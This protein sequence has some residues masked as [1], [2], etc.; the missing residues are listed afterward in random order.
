M[1][2]NWFNF[3]SNVDL[4]SLFFFALSGVILFIC[5]GLFRSSAPTPSKKKV[6]DQLKSLKTSV[7]QLQPN[8]TEHILSSVNMPASRGRTRKNYSNLVKE[9]IAAGEKG[10][11]VGMAS[12]PLTIQNQVGSS[13][14]GVDEVSFEGSQESLNS[15]DDGETCTVESVQS[16]SVAPPNPPNIDSQRYVRGV[17]QP[18][19]PNL[20]SIQ[21]IKISE[22]V[23]EQVNNEDY[24]GNDVVESNFV[25]VQED[26]SQKVIHI[27]NSERRSCY[28]ID[29]PM[30]IFYPS[31]RI[32]HTVFL[33]RKTSFNVLKDKVTSNSVVYVVGEKGLGKTTLV[34]H[35][36]QYA[37]LE[38]GFHVLSFSF[39][40]MICDVESACNII[41]Q[42]QLG[43]DYSEIDNSL[44]MLIEYLRNNKIL[45]VL[46]HCEYLSQQEVLTLG[47]FYD[48][49]SKVIMVFSGDSEEVP[50]GNSERVVQLSS[51]DQVFCQNL[52]MKYVPDV[53][54]FQSQSLK[55]IQ[56]LS[57]GNLLSLEL[58]GQYCM[59][60]SERNKGEYLKQSFFADR[61]REI[62]E[63]KVNNKSTL[64]KLFKQSF[65]TLNNLEKDVLTIIALLP[66]QHLSEYTL[67]FFIPS[68][69]SINLK[70]ILSDL[71]SKG[72][73][74]TLYI[75]QDKETL[76]SIHSAFK[77][78]LRK[79]AFIEPDLH[80][81]IINASLQYCLNICNTESLFEKE[82]LSNT[83]NLFL[84]VLE[85]CS[86]GDTFIN[87]YQ[88]LFDKVIRFAASCGFE[89]TIVNNIIPLI[90]DNLKEAVSN[91]EILL[92]KRYLGLSIILVADNVE[93]LDKGMNLVK[94][95]HQAYAYSPAHQQI[96]LTLLAKG[97]MKRNSL[98]KSDSHLDSAIEA[99]E[100]AHNLYPLEGLELVELKMD[101][102]SA[103]LMKH[104][105]SHSELN[106]YK[107]EYL[108]KALSLFN[109]INQTIKEEYLEVPYSFASVFYSEY[110]SL[111]MQVS[112]IT[113][114]AEYLRQAINQSKEALRYVDRVVPV[115]INLGFSYWQLIK[116]DKEPA[117]QLQNVEQA[118]VHYKKAL[119]LL[120]KESEQN[121]A[122][123]SNPSQKDEFVLIHNNLGTCY[124]YLAS[125]QEQD[126]NYAL[127]FKHFKKALIQTQK[128]GEQDLIE[129]AQQHLLELY[130]TIQLEYTFKHDSDNR[131][132]DVDILLSEIREELRD[133]IK[134]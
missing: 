106:D 1:L 81:S 112:Q 31:L 93:D 78:F 9:T 11:S 80:R 2:H 7:V 110:A 104:E 5:F 16:L 69:H 130:N 131:T 21:D 127:S 74:N 91:D 66:F 60:W 108:H 128:Y 27:S 113:A 118:V 48:Q 56:D 92:W 103:Y 4:T 129:I 36:S 100:E 37:Y 101:L 13:V 17:D 102:A 116:F 120:S 68:K 8:D 99:Y 75:K 22:P 77:D 109:C 90:Q 86:K 18:V 89:G 40:D 39:G 38:G 123:A 71:R 79:E 83:L 35:Y 73:L 97:H 26:V 3:I 117:V 53:S 46:D 107:Y 49:C 67:S 58:F 12:E 34:S 47:N 133:S 121:E 96:A 59:Q 134:C 50:S 51:F 29:S 114:S 82:T 70:D 125:L 42:E 15:V 32:D 20:T 132:Q 23:V 111:L 122:L 85:Y 25:Q 14:L 76:Y 55:S 94:Q 45:L 62:Q 98:E 126:K 19:S 28:S 88:H 61:I 30:P 119:N 64:C 6:N 87:E 84:Y 44:D 105:L 65:L 10:Q 54:V 24:I 57:Q 63:V 95:Y 33:D 115:H 52:L 72:L 43:I 124:K 41:L